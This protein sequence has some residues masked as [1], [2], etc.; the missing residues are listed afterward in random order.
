LY[1]LKRVQTAREQFRLLEQHFLD[2]PQMVA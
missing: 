2:S 1:D